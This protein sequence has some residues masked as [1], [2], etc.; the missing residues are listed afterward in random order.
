MDSN[1]LLSAIG[2]VWAFYGAV[3]LA[4]MGYVAFPKKD[5]QVH[6][7]PKLMAACLLLFF[8]I[9]FIAVMGLQFALIANLS[10]ELRAI[11]FP[12]HAALL[13]LHLML[14]ICVVLL[15]YSVLTDNVVRRSRASRPRARGLKLVKRPLLP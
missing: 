7:P 8:M 13:V 12:V 3:Q 10:L 2:A 4:L 14:D 1:T 15:V 9:S 11:A 6:A 5:Q